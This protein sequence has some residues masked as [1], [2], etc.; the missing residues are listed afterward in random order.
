M[1]QEKLQP[2]TQCKIIDNGTVN[3]GHL[4][5][6][7]LRNFAPGGTP[8]ANLEPLNIMDELILSVNDI[9]LKESRLEASLPEIWIFPDKTQRFRIN[10]D[11]DICK[12][13]SHTNRITWP[14]K[15]ISAEELVPPH[16]GGSTSGPTASESGC[17]NGIVTTISFS[18]QN[19]LSFEHWIICS[20]LLKHFVSFK[21]S[22]PTPLQSTFRL[23]TTL[24][25]RHLGLF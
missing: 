15:Q 11:L 3:W 19:Y 2:K 20:I 6:E 9:T 25:S 16:L 22:D 21:T 13:V 23:V 10:N 5:N 24:H 4:S 14:P 12:N 7:T 1:C 18:K 17:K 8:M